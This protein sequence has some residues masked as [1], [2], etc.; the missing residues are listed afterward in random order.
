MFRHD[1]MTDRQVAPHA[2]AWIETGK[3]YLSEHGN[4]VAPHAGAWI[5][6][7]FRAPYVL[8]VAGRTPRGCVD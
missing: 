6:T 8:R 5:E 2:G 1:V 3:K 7:S 4:T